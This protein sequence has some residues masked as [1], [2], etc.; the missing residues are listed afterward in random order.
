MALR[1]AI[2]LL[3]A[4][5]IAYQILLIR[6]FSIIQWHHYAYMVISLA[7]LGYGAS[8]TFLALFR[9]P[10]Q[11]RFPA[12]FLWNAVLFSILSLLCFAAA[13]ALP[14]NPL[15]TIWDHRQL[16]YLALIYLLLALPFF[17]VANCPASHSLRAVSKYLPKPRP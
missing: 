3:S 12:A 9:R 1:L 4:A 17:C 2:T 8:G 15:E 7:L 5:A 16:Y 11:D 13:Q 6:L 10:L 14:F